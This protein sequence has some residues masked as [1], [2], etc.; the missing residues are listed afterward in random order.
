GDETNEVRGIR[1]SADDSRISPGAIS[2]EDFA[3]TTIDDYARSM[4]RLDFIKM[5]IE[6]AEMAALAGASNA[7]REFRPRLAISGYHK[8]EDLWEIPG[9]MRQLN[10]GYRLAFGHHTPV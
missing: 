5:D 2:T 6:G 3:C 4:R 10:P 8:P 9:R 1:S 7:I